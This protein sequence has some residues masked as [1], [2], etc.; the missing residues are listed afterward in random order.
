MELSACDPGSRS[1]EMGHL[2]PEDLGY[3]LPTQPIPLLLRTTTTT[4]NYVGSA[5][6]D[7]EDDCPLDI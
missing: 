2:L 6:T 1:D 3:Q 4:T 5:D 7:A